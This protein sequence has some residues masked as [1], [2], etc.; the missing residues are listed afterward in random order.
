VR[1]ELDITLT[2]ERAAPLYLRSVYW[3]MVIGTS[4]RGTGRTAARAA[5]I[6][7]NSVCARMRRCLGPRADQ[8]TRRFRQSKTS[9]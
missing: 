6:H 8:F 1:R 2:A 5:W 4:D 3:A 9:A 7:L